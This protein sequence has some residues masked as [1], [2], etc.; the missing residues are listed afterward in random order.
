MK[1]SSSGGWNLYL[2]D[3]REPP[4]GREWVVCRSSSEAL[5]AI[6]ERGAPAFASLDHD[7]GD[8]DTT[9]VFLR[10]LVS[11]LW[12]GISPPPDYQIHSANPVGAQNI[13]SFME[14]WRRSVRKE[15]FK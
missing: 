5:E 4:P 10:R 3:L 6:A 11:E 15:G 8:Q 1:G 2:D 13:R 7:L 9:M 14:S 12:D